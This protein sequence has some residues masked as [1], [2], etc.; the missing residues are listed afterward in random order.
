M[1][2]QRQSRLAH[3]RKYMSVGHKTYGSCLLLKHG[4]AKII[5]GKYCSVADNVTAFLGYNHDPDRISIYPM[6]TRIK[7]GCDENKYLSNG[8][9]VVGNDVWIGSHAVLMSGIT[10]GNG[11]IIG[12]YSVVAKDVPPYTVAVGNPVVIKRKRFSGETIELL[13]KIAW[14]DWP[15]EK[16]KQ[17]ADILTS[18]DTERL[19][20]L[21]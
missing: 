11:A 20:E 16:V 18:K 19:K 7:A 13:Q 21:I 2:I 6:Q 15:D 8:N 10:I 9:I 3:N 12:A 4:D 14:W 17:Y 5:I 1:F